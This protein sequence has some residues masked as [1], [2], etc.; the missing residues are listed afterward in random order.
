M[1]KVFEKAFYMLLGHEGGFVD[2]IDDPGGKT[3]YGISQRAYPN[4]DIANI[5]IDRAKFLY[6]RDYWIKSNCDDVANIDA[7]IAIELFDTAV[8]C[9]V[10]KSAKIFQ[11]ALNLSNRNQRDYDDIKIDGDIGS[12]TIGALK[13]CKIRVFLLNMMN[14]LQAEH[15]INIQRK[16]SKSEKYIGW[17]TQRIKIIK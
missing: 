9:G 4:E 3:N 11:E 6:H 14:F 5:T 12:K 10:G 15:Y 2:D 1:K 8:N 17:F 13:L 16:R 7:M